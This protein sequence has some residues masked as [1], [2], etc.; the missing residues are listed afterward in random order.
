MRSGQLITI[1][2]GKKF[3]LP[4]EVRVVQRSNFF[5]G[6]LAR[7]RSL[8]GVDAA[9]FVRAVPGQGYAGDGGFAIAEHPPLPAGQMQSAI[10]RWADPGYFQAMGIPL[11]RGAI[12]DDSQLLEKA[13]RVVISES[14][15]RQYFGAGDPI[16]K[17]LLTL[18]GK[19]FE[20]SG[21][22]GDTRFTVSKPAQP[23]M[24]FSIYSGEFG[25]T[26]LVV[27]SALDVNTLA[28]PI[29]R[30]VQQ[31]DP[32]LAVMD[33]LTMNQILG[34]DTLDASFDAILLLVFSVLSLLLAAVGL[35][36]VLSYSVA[37]RTPE[38][39]I[40]IALGAQRDQVL[41]L[42][43]SE[44]LRPA[45]VG[46]VLGLLASVGVTRLVQSMLYKTQ[47][48]DPIVFLSVTATLLLVAAIACVWPAW[49]TSRLDPMETLRSD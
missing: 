37:R 7:V 12:F 16:G 6:L 8:P 13:N 5:A 38:I 20:I 33:I 42:I 35:F 32:E 3:W 9:G 29:Q 41:R 21:I 40:R 18:G 10:V 2:C 47:P 24:Y 23:M 4:L 30:A 45:V 27:R 48:L 26:G 22:V 44:G 46:L 19:P 11:I 43:L 15:A 28:L 49:R 14:F 36:G 1:F 25:S 34:R 17:H 39:G 31:L